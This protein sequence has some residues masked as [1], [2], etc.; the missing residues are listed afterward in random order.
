MQPV[1]Q[2]LNLRHYFQSRI[3]LK[4]GLLFFLLVFST[5]AK[6]QSFE[7]SFA[8]GEKFEPNGQLEIPLTSPDEFFGGVYFRLI[9][10]NTLPTIE[11]RAAL[12]QHGIELLDYIPN[13]AY[14]ACIS[15]MANLSALTSF[16]VRFVGKIN[17]LYKISKQIADNMVPEHAFVNDSIAYTFT[18]Y[19]SCSAEVVNSFFKNSIYRITY[20]NKHAKRITVQ[21][22]YTKN[23]DIKVIAKIP[24]ISYVEFKA[25]PPQPENKSGRTLH[26]SNA[27]ANDFISGRHYNGAGINVAL[28]DDGV[29][30]PHIDYTGRLPQQYLDYNL[31]DHG[32]HC[33]GTIF[34][35]GNKDP[36]GRGMAWGANLYVYKASQYQGFDSIYNHYISPGIVITST[37]YS[38]GCN[39]GYTS[40]SEELDEQI[41][42]MPLLMHVFSAGNEGA[43]DCDYGAGAGWGNITGGH[44]ASKNSIAVGNLDFMDNLNSSS[45]RGP[46]E[47]GRLKPEVC[48][49][50][51]SVYSTIDANDYAS[52]TGTSMACPGV[53]GTLAQLYQAYN[54]ING[55]NPPSGLLKCIL[56]NTCDDL[57]NTGPDY[58][59]GY[60]R[61]NALRA[62]KLIETNQYINSSI[63]TG[64]TNTH[65]L[66]IPMGTL[67]ARIMVYWNDYEAT[68]A[69]ATVLVNDIDMR[70]IDP[71]MANFFPY[72][73][74]PTPSVA[75]LNAPATNGVDVLNNHE[76][77]VLVNPLPGM[78]TIEINGTS[79]P[80]GPQDYFIAYEFLTDEITLTSPMGG[81]NFAPAEPE[82]IRWDAYGN[83]GTFLLE[84][85]IDSGLTWTSIATVAATSRAFNWSVPAVISGKCLV[86]VTRGAI[87]DQSDAVFSIINIPTSL[88]VAYSCPDTL[89]LTWNPVV[90][91]TSY[92]VFMLGNVYMDSIANTTTTSIEIAMPYINTTWF[93]VRA[94]G[95]LNA[96]G[97]R[98]IA[99][100]KFPVLVACDLLL[101]AGLNAVVSPLPVNCNG[102]GMETV[103]IEIVNG[104]TTDLL[105]V[106][107][108]YQVNSGAVV[109]EIYADTIYPGDT[110]TYNFTTLANL[111]TPG[112]YIIQTWVNYGGDLNI[113]NDTTQ[114]FIDSS[115][116]YP[117]TF[118]YSEDFET[119]TVCGTTTGCSTVSCPLANGWKNMLNT[120][121]DDTD[122][123]PNAGSTPTNNTGPSQDFLPGDTTGKYVYIEAS[124]CALKVAH[125]T[126]PCI[127][128]SAALNPVLEFAYHMY[129]A[130]IA[131]L[132]VDVYNGGW[133]EDVKVITGDQGD[134]WGTTVASLSAFAGSGVKIR[135]RGY[136]GFS[137]SSDLAIDAVKVMEANS[138]EEIS[139]IGN[140]NVFPNPNTGEFTVAIENTGENT[141]LIIRDVLGRQI[142]MQNLQASSTKTMFDLSTNP[143]GIY[144][145]EISKGEKSKTV[146][147]VKVK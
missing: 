15:S 50:G 48:A 42:T 71:S 60:G 104:G 126:S 112:N 39:E 49:K 72:V 80:Q 138:V 24:F 65:T 14:T 6:S 137:S 18:Y 7:I 84:Y 121:E 66:N 8:S 115:S 145:L 82:I 92:D 133:V 16:N 139:S 73:L 43:Q 105:N 135:F 22:A 47:D 29:I 86:R 143:N 37:S 55:S 79:I 116:Y 62:A 91:A 26:R 119:F 27:I 46:V 56:M 30:G 141:L 68:P 99:I 61:I 136:T 87:S 64:T 53:A 147:L 102:Y 11:Q 122:W 32:D 78:H 58:K 130:S 19:S 120:D 75:N 94:R 118:P 106:P 90:G 10:F 74:D 93:A 23:F 57:G 35:A 63:T 125:M 98:N 54:L 25:A 51:T 9:Q 140:Y 3:M 76:Q 20:H 36:D 17:P 110:V 123:R 83:A 1:L 5:Y 132:H 4:T 111:S 38:D 109:N 97:K 142:Q 124:S 89:Q 108:H 40:L 96:V 52:K 81:E 2:I 107:V 59:F 146:K 88:T 95:P 12:K 45:S 21:T 103:S 33:A 131:S 67:E 28:Q 144:Y 77:I 100:E 34:G 85:S 70:V 114:I 127:D 13:K 129:G 101:D 31:G 113:Y 134:Q 128:L 44:K 69:A 41:R 117:V